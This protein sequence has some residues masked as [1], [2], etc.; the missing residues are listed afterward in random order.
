MI[1][2]NAY[3][4]ALNNLLADANSLGSTPD[5][6]AARA[7]ALAE[8]RHALV[9][10]LVEEPPP[11]RGR[12]VWGVA[13]SGADCLIGD[14]D[15]EGREVCVV[16]DRLVDYYPNGGFRCAAQETFADR[17]TALRCAAAWARA[18]GYEC[19][20]HPDAA[21]A[22]QP[23]AHQQQPPTDDD[24]WTPWS[25]GECP[26]PD[27]PEVEYECRGGYRGIY[28]PTALA[29]EHYDQS[30]DIIAYRRPRP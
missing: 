18:D 21:P 24:A 15:C 20:D 1:D 16:T 22:E 3:R 27:W 19:D 4:H 29:W 7:L 23:P 9:A 25:G 6:L 30:G 26:C 14:G 13:P 8:W 17:V 12:L 10:G 5:E 28:S 11:S 2:R